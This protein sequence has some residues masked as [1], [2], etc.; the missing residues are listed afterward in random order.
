MSQPA[1]HLEF[2]TLSE[3]LSAQREMFLAQATAGIKTT[4]ADAMDE[5]VRAGVAERAVRIG[6]PAPAFTLPNAMGREVSLHA[7]LGR[8]PVVL[9]FYRGGWCPYCNVELRALQGELPRIRASGAQLIA[10]SPQTPDHSLNT[11][12]KHNLS[13]EVLS[14]LGNRIAR[15]Y[16]LV[17]TLP[18]ALRPLYRSW[19]I[20]LRE[21]NGDD[22]HELPVPATYVIDQEGMVRAAYVNVDYTQRLE[23]ADILAALRSI[24][25]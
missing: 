17:F 21:W 23:P 25:R 22:S 6:Q 1:N 7:T 19:G 4:M 8:G 20:D 5:L 16:G 12:A 18:E 10:V 11:A 3:E 2:P 14:D 9:S 15:A 13:F 24:R